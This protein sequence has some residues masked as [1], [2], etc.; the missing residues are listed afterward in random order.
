VESASGR[1]RPVPTRRATRSELA[2]GPRIPREQATA[3]LTALL[4]TVCAGG[5]Y[6]DCITAVHAFGS[7]AR[8]ALDVGDVDT[9]IEYDARLNPRVERELLDN[10][11]VGRDWNTPFRRRSSRPARCR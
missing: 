8:G 10:L 11:V 5:P 1:L 4:E 3:A 7:Y 9:D 6:A 2:P